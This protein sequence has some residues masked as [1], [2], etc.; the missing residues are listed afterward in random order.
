[1][2]GESEARSEKGINPGLKDRE[3][4]TLQSKCQ[5]Q[6]SPMPRKIVVESTIGWIPANRC[7]SLIDPF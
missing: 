3:L 1:M 5:G 4:M 7:V 6:S 2:G